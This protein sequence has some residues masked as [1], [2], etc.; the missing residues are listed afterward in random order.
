MPCVKKLGFA[1]DSQCPTERRSPAMPRMCNHCTKTDPLVQ[2]DRTLRWG[3]TPSSRPFFKV[4]EASRL[5]S[6]AARI[7]KA[8]DLTRSVL[9]CGSPLPLL[10]QLHSKIGRPL[11]HRPNPPPDR[12]GHDD[13]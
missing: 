7:S 1:V 12:L 4:A 3:E 2:R 10:S 8:S 13:E 9:D 11:F 5:C 6:S